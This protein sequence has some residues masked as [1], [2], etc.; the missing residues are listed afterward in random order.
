MSN[1]ILKRKT[2]RALAHMIAIHPSVKNGFEDC[3][4][5]RSGN[6]LTN[7]FFDC[8]FEYAHDGSSRTAWVEDRLIDLFGIDDSD[9]GIQRLIT[10]LSNLMDI[11]DVVGNDFDR[12]QAL[13]L[14]NN[15]LQR[16]NYQGFYDSDKKFQLR[17]IDTQRAIKEKFNP[18]DAFTQA[19]RERIVLLS[20][21]LSNCS[22]DNL[23]ENILLPLFDQL[24]FK[25]VKLAGHKDKGLEYGKDMWMYYELPTQH[26]IYFGIQVKK[27]KIDSAGKSKGNVAELYN[28]CLMMLDNP[29]HD[30]TVN[31]NVLVDHVY[32]ISG[33]EITKQARNWLVQKLNQSQRRAI[34]FM[35][36]DEIVHLFAKT[37]IDI[38]KP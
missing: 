1:A 8:D 29:I 33:H 28:Q 27:G 5:Y 35:D 25:R 34:I 20:S 36:R 24:N 23:I 38:P 13:A 11:S 14:L 15:E 16:D 17:E 18:N 7:F 10:V 30:D 22:E 21:Y 32:I 37:T 19:Q 4:I 3:F 9:E 2:I 26:R 12:S 6:A 31:R